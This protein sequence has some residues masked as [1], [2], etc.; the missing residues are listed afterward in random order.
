MSDNEIVYILQQNLED[1]LNGA[2]IIVLSHPKIKHSVTTYML[3]DDISGAERMFD[4]LEEELSGLDDINKA[5][6]IYN[7][8][9]EEA[10]ILI[11]ER[12]L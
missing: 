8:I 7:K 11:N 10:Q 6:K 2:N 5:M 4:I 12:H 3:I 1:V 9:I